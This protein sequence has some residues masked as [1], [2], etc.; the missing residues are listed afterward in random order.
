ML[1]GALRAAKVLQ[2]SMGS[3]LKSA[4]AIFSSFGKKIK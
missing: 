1:I 4:K 3:H 2:N